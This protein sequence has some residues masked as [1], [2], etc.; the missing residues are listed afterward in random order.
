MTGS[1]MVLL[2]IYMFANI[3]I[4]SFI[5][6]GNLSFCTVLRNIK[7][8]GQYRK[9]K[10]LFIYLYMY[11]YSMITFILLFQ[12]ILRHENSEPHVTQL[13][14][15]FTS[16]QRFSGVCDVAILWI[17]DWK[18]CCVFPDVLCL[19][20]LVVCDDCI[21]MSCSCLKVI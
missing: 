11:Q 20:Q 18:L 1:E 15:Q 3:L 2:L 4:L 5:F 10:L 19:S 7:F 8:F 12:I 6:T 13:R 16:T 9:S 14:V 17:T 21:Q